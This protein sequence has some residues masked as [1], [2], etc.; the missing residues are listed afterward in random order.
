M[1]LT[2]QTRNVS[3]FLKIRRQELQMKDNITWHHLF[4]TALTDYFT[5][6]RYS[7][8]P[9]KD[10]SAARQF[11]DALILRKSEG[12]EPEEPPDGLED[13]GDYNL[14]TYKSH[15]QALDGW[16]VKELLGHYVGYRK[17]ISPKGKLVPEECFRLYAVST[18]FPENLSEQVSLKDYKKGVCD[19]G[20]GICDI[21]LIVLS[22]VSEDKRNALWHMFSAIPEAVRRGA[23]AYG[24]RR[25]DL[26]TVMN[27]LLLKYRAEG[28][29]M[30]YTVEDYKREI[31]EEVIGDL[32]ADEVM[33]HYSADLRLKG[34]SADI[35]LKG[36]SADEVLKRYPAD[37]VLK[38]Y[39]TDE[40]LNAL[41][42]NSAPKK[43]KK[44]EALIKAIREEED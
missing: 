34:L 4:V 36:L 43:R 7:V 22:R 5:D 16:A 15:H 38:R 17:L 1:F 25:N 28:I 12:K 8:E 10:T 19:I 29:V 27:R 14:I 32:P 37:E 6:T 44:I 40:V 24:W 42:K 26:S 2:G 39:P 18:R 35:R 41:L 13:M 30:P 23:A 3:F 20:L 9:E 33:K 21:R 11:L 31:V